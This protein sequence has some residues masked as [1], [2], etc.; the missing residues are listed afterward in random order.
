MRQFLPRALLM[1][2]VLAVVSACGAPAAV[3][4]QATSA[5]QPT[6][7]AATEAPA[8][9]TAAATETP[10]AATATEA[11]ATP[12]EAPPTAAPTTTTAPTAT[13]EP[14]PTAD[15]AANAPQGQD[16][17]NLLLD[18]AKAQLAQKAWRTTLTITDADGKE[19][20]STIEFVKPDSL[21][22][23]TPGQE[24]IVVKDGTFMK[25]GAD[26]WIKSP[27]DMSG[28]ITDLLSQQGLESIMK[29]VKYEDIKLAGVDM[30]NGKPA[31]IY[32]YKSSMDVGGTKVATDS[33]TWIGVLD[34][35][36]YKIEGVSNTD[37]GGKTTVVGVY[38]Y[39]DNITIEAPNVTG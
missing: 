8:A 27:V 29:D 34:K 25:R 32:Q 16:A 38:E 26:K 37:K 19:T 14:S 39:P 10:A 13:T 18:A 20:Q 6:A 3:P 7:P 17:F 23:A 21:H 9:T 31:W 35:L 4:S 15:A 12:T 1:V 5:P 2:V 30:I 11:P 22:M 36:P 28:M 33:K 24:I